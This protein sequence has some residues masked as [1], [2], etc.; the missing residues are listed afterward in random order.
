VGISSKV[1]GNRHR[2]Q[3]WQRQ[4]YLESRGRWSWRKFYDPIADI[5]AAREY[6]RNLS[7]EAMENARWSSLKANLPT[8]NWKP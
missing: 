7:W 5:L 4:V 6:L 1:H 8:E 3:R 2:L